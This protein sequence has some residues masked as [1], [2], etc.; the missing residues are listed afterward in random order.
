M[1]I[2]IVGNK[3]ANALECKVGEAGCTEQAIRDELN[4]NGKELACL[5]EVKLNDSGEKYYNYIYYDR[6]ETDKYNYQQNSSKDGFINKYGAGSTTSKYDV[7]ING[8]SLESNLC[9]KNSYIFRDEYWDDYVC[10][11]S[12]GESCLS[13]DHNVMSYE[14]STFKIISNDI[15]NVIFKGTDTYKQYRDNKDFCVYYIPESKYDNSYVVYSKNE[16]GLLF[17]QDNGNKKFTV[18][19][20][21]SQNEKYAFSS[22]DSTFYKNDVNSSSCPSNIYLYSKS[23]AGSIRNKYF[24]SELYGDDYE[25][26]LTFELYNS[27]NKNPNLNVEE[28]DCDMFSPELREIINQVMNIVRIAIPLLLIGL[29]TLDFA[30]ATFAADDKAIAKSKKNAITRIIIAVVIF[31]VPTILNLIFDIANDIWAN[32]HYEICVLEEND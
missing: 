3:S 26:D 32:A 10:F 31:F 29:I 12:D 27:S 20:K 25:L 2:F 11:D 16:K 4:S 14:E 19:L 13:Y 17:F 5:Y 21:S 28:V 30:K 18:G 24:T 22:T 6:I 7:A 9:P 23:G 1:T 8:K 15:D